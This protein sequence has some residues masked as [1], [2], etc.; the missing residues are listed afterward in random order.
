[1]AKAKDNPTNCTPTSKS[2][3]VK[4]MNELYNTNGGGD[5]A[6]CDGKVGGVKSSKS[7]KE[8]TDDIIRDGSHMENGKLKPNIRYQTGEH[9]YIYETNENGLIAHASTEEL[10]L[11]EHEGRLHHDKNTYDK[12]DNDHAG[13]IFG[14]RFGGSPELDNLVSQ[15]RQVN[16]SEFKVI[17]NE[18]AA[19]LKR[20][21]KV[22][23]DITINY[24][25]ISR[26]PISF[27]VSYTIKDI[28]YYKFIEN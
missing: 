3:P 5:K 20:G 4:E 23:V 17:E 22:T 21:E 13:H 12:D 11:K 25:E 2:D 18:W 28:P 19:A 7:G 14:D 15:A 27:D 9:E 8:P 24:S 1:M 16:L 10:K 6:G 26:R